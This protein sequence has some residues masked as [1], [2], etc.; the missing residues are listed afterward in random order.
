MLYLKYLAE[1]M[2]ALRGH[3][4]WGAGQHLISNCTK[5]DI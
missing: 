3:Y 1:L 5:L 2:P 4:L